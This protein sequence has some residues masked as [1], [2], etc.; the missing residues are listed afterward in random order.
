MIALLRRQAFPLLIAAVAIA[1]LGLFFLIP[2][3]KVFDA[4]ILDAS[5]KVLTFANYETVLSNRFFL[6]GLT[7]SLMIAI[8]ASAATIAIGVPL[9]C[10]SHCQPC[11]WCCRR[12]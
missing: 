5:G 3:W 4:S 9:A 10:C 12:S 6:S 1:V 11:R 8:S 2:L 7:N